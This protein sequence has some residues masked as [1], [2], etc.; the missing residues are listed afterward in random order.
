MK[1]KQF[2]FKE[3]LAGPIFIACL[4]HIILL[5]SWLFERSAP[6]L[7]TPQRSI[8]IMLVPPAPQKNTQAFS[9]MEESLSAI[10][11]R[12]KNEMRSENLLKKRTISEAFHRPIEADYLT[13][14]QNYVEQFGNAHYPAQV[15]KQNLQGQLRLLVA[16]NRDGSLRAVNIRQSSGSPMLDKAAIQIVKQA[17]PFEPLPSDLQDLDVL[18]IIRTWQFRGNLTTSS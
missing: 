4:L 14:W 6:L 16:V 2:L 11:E 18:E 13:R 10:S 15:L 3:G 8:D 1:I 12:I 7:P 9:S 5:S 17:A